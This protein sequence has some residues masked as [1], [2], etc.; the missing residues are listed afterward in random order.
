MI[1]RSASENAE[2]KPRSESNERK[3][4]SEATSLFVTLRRFAS[5][6]APLRTVCVEAKRAVIALVA[7][8]LLQELQSVP[9]SAT[10]NE[11]SRVPDPVL[12]G[13]ALQRI[14]G[15][16]S[17]PGKRLPNLVR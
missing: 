6:G 4:R 13:E 16:H 15:H 2:R 14:P 9:E 8:S 11:D 7:N 12:P 1:V 5:H 17:V 10:A 3:T